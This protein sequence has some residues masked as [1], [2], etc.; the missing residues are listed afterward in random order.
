MGALI[1][2]V[3]SG[4]WLTRARMRRWA[5]AVLIASAAGLGFLIVTAQ[6]VVDFKGRPLGTDFS[7]VYAAGR[8]VLEGQAAAP[9]DPVLQQRREQALF[10]ADTPFYGWHYPPFFLFI[11][12]PLAF[13]PYGLALAVWQAAT[14]A[15]YLLAMRAVAAT[16]TCAAP[17]MV[18]TH[19]RLWLLL[20]LAFPAVLV[21]L[22]HGHNGFL[23]AALITGALILLDRRPI[24]A[25]LLFG[26]IAYK[27]QF[28]VLIPLVLVATGRWR[29]CLA[30]G[31]TVAALVIAA[32][33]VFGGEIWTAFL[34]STQFTREIVLEAGNTGWHKIQ[35][36]FSW[37]RLWGGSI[38][39]AYAVQGVVTAAVAAA[40]I[41]VWRS[42]ASPELKA[43]VLPVGA[44]I[45]TP[46]ALDYDMMVLAPAVAFFAVDGLARGFRGYE[47]TMLAVLWL[48][49][50]LARS[51]TELTL[52]PVGVLVMLV[53]FVLMIRRAVDS[54]AAAAA[55]LSR[56]V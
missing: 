9:F 44:I 25:G 35:S 17:A 1:E 54:P 31:A 18:R 42:R 19:D 46:Y 38:A 39:L 5:L 48:V 37:V 24:T 43:A 20:A 6:G 22:G 51:V 47:K 13:M 55:P 16:A 28:G 10:G 34:A 50:M 40:A 33:I 53:A 12:A 23:T 36:I 27:P 11:A 26:L 45:T 4:A 56:A 21:N 41:A 30:A 2:M 8:Q 29:T 3:R 7:N 52:V 15:L 32:T 14:L 49:P